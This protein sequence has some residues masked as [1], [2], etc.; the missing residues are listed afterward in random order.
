MIKAAL[1]MLA[2]AGGQDA[3][4]SRA[5][6]IERLQTVGANTATAGSC[7]LVGYEFDEDGMSAYWREERGFAQ[8]DGFFA[9]QA[10]TYIELGMDGR[11]SAILS[12]MKRQRQKLEAG[13]RTADA[14]TRRFVDDLV[15]ACDLLASR[16]ETRRL[17]SY[18]PANASVARAAGLKGLGILK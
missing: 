18:A 8:A 16:S 5:R 1:V 4:P 7:D 9:E 10:Q 14:D 17:F 11:A 12:E 3:Q 13:D 2:L 15:E 6:T